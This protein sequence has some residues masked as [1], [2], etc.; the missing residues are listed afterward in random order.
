MGDAQDES[1]LQDQFTLTHFA[2]WDQHLTLKNYVKLLLQ[3]IF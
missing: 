2:I 1:F 3:N